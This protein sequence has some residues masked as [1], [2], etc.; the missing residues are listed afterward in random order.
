MMHT[1]A[2]G[3]AI[4]HYLATKVPQKKRLRG[5][6][7]QKMANSWRCRFEWT[8]CPFGFLL[9]SLPSKQVLIIGLTKV[10]QLTSPINFRKSHRLNIKSS[11]DA[12]ETTYGSGFRDRLELEVRVYFFGLIQPFI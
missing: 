1:A 12:P 10:S 11:M 7:R 3:E 9:C 5:L 2:L 4:M 6:T 8:A